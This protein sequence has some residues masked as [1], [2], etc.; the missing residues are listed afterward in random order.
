MTIEKNKEKI[1]AIIQARMS[2]KRLPGKVLR[3]INGIPILEH[4]TSKVKE[5]RFINT[6]IIATTNEKEDLKLV[7]YHLNTCKTTYTLKTV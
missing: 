7:G 1:G 5:S 2:S 4:I 6:C 3:L